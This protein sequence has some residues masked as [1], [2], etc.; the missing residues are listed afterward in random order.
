M[1]WARA[2][3]RARAGAALTLWRAPKINV[4]VGPMLVCGSDYAVGRRPIL[5]DA[6]KQPFSIVARP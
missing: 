1:A 3:A 6:I 4:T 2:G 5:E